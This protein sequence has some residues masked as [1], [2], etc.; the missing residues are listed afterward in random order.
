MEKQK[1]FYG[2]NRRKYI[3]E[4]LINSETPITGTELAEKTNVSRQVIV[5]DI[6]LLR[7]K[8]HAIIATSQ[9]YLY[10]R[11]MQNK[12]RH[13]TIVACQHTPEQMEQELELLI[14]CGVSIK[15]VTV[16]H[17]IYGDLTAPLMLHTEHDV[18]RFTKKMKE[19]NASLLSEL[20]SGIH[21]HTLESDDP[22]NLI[23]ATQQLKKHGFLLSN[24]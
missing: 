1:K 6:S 19:K 10:M 23:M 20:T 11:Q 21:L 8:N 4:L 15:D 3:L 9:G 12:K 13:S 5:S 2:E 7:A 22:N 14:K 18:K 24:D 17:P 16:E